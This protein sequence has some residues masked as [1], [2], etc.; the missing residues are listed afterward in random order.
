MLSILIASYNRNVVQLIEELNCQLINSKIDFEIICFDDASNSKENLANQIINN[1]PFCSFQSLQ[2]NIGR[3]AIRNLLASKAKY[4][5]LLFLDA[6]VLPTS[7][8]FIS[9]YL[10]EIK[11]TKYAVFLGGIKYRDIDNKNLLRW[12]FGKQSEEISIIDRTK[13]PYKYFFTANFLIDKTTFESVKFNEDLLEYGYE[14]LLFSK[15]L[16]SKNVKIKQTKNEVFHLGIDENLAFLSKTKKAILN[17]HILL[18]K[19]LLKEEDT[20]LTKVYFKYKSFG[21]FRFLNLFSDVLEKLA[22]KKSSVFYYNLFRLV[23][24]HQVIKNR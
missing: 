8:T 23:Y 19:G 11:K 6:D 4:K 21:L 15:E 13:N 12:K 5:W 20:N 18:Q 24:L 9:N 2:K 17:L 1:L 10:Q 7:S 16:Y 22:L 3:S 14:D